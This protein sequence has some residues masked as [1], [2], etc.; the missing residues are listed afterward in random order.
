MREFRVFYV[1][2]E[3]LEMHEI[4][5]EHFLK[6]WRVQVIEGGMAL[7]NDR[8]LTETQALE[9]FNNRE[10]ET[11]DQGYCQLREEMLSY[12]TK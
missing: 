12:T 2:I 3:N 5:V 6:G 11:L 7:V 9:S 8:G 10:R 1:H 4:R